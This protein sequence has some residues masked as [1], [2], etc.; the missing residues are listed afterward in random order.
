LSCVLRQYPA[1]KVIE[2]DGKASYHLSVSVVNIIV[3]E[4]PP[5][6]SLQEMITD[7][8]SLTEKMVFAC[9]VGLEQTRS[10]FGSEENIC[11]GC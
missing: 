7:D 4:I 1:S 11:W 2:L 5:K 6:L 10:P 9:V 3:A 8:S